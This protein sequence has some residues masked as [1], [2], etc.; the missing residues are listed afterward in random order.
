MAIWIGLDVE[1]AES[2]DQL[3]R[4]SEKNG[5]DFTYAIADPDLSR[6]LVADF[7]EVVL[8]P[9]STNVI[10]IG[11]GG[12]I[13]HTTGGLNSDEIVELAASHRG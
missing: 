6:A 1:T 4:Y 9:P 12:L 5:F 8:N 10:V 11:T 7:G 2:A 3:A 13:T